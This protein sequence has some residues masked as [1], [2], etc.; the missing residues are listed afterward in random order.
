MAPHLTAA[1]LDFAFDIERLV[2]IFT[3][4]WHA[5]AGDV[6]SLPPHFIA[7]ARCSAVSPI[8]AHARKPV[9]GSGS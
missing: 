9:G 6:A 4:H 2:W 5:S 3:R 8:G 7:F 1:E